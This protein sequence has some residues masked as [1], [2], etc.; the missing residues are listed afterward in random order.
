MLPIRITLAGCSTRS[1][2]SRTSS[3][4]PSPAARASASGLVDRGR[5]YGARLAVGADDDDLLL[6][7][8][9]CSLM[10]QP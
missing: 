5:R 7:S 10:P 3:P 8:F 9:G 1:V 4:S 6:G 2:R